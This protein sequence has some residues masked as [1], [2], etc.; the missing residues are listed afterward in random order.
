MLERYIEHNLEAL[1]STLRVP[2]YARWMSVAQS[3]FRTPSRASSKLLS[4]GNQ[5][6]CAGQR[7]CTPARSLSRSQSCASPTS[8]SMTLASENGRGAGGELYTPL[9]N[10][11]EQRSAGSGQGF[12]S[13]P[14]APRW[15]SKK[16]A[17]SQPRNRLLA[18][19]EE[20][21]EHSARSGMPV[22]EK[23]A[24]SNPVRGATHF[25]NS[26]GGSRTATRGLR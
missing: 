7:P 15:G 3:A 19:C 4:V 13:S 1:E 17:I 23:A 26:D 24:G 18:T 16:L 10:L 21:R 11:P 2:I 6:N 5:A 22:K 12:S 8:T 25:G 20:G 14:A 9:R